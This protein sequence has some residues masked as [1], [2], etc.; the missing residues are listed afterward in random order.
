MK[1]SR[2]RAQVAPERLNYL[3]SGRPIR[4]GADPPEV[5]NGLPD[6]LESLF[7]RSAATHPHTGQLPHG[8]AQPGPPSRT[9]QQSGPPRI[10]AETPPSRATP[11]AASIRSSPDPPDWLEAPNV[12]VPP[13]PEPERTPA[14]HQ[15]PSAADQN[16][17]NSR[18][19][20][21]LAPGQPGVRALAAIGVL[22]A[23]IASAYLWTSRP[24]PEATP[25]HPA[26]PSLISAPPDSA[27]RQPQPTTTSATKVFVHV[28][29]K[30]RRPGV[31]SLTAGS[32]VTDAI[33]A[34]G[35]L[36]PGARTGPLNL[37]R[38]LVDG[39]QLR[40][41]IPGHPEPPA[42]PNPPS[43]PATATT[44]GAPTPLDLNTATEEQF[45]ALPGVG[46]VLARRIIDYRTRNGGFRTVEQ[47]QEVSGIG[48][49][50]YA[51]LKPLVRV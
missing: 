21:R 10:R 50:R 45:D 4:P 34:A 13:P 5:F 48:T 31:V 20:A 16:T 19:L 44:P 51:D 47:L 6:D 18:L 33:T 2:K 12:K 38:R 15:L 43:D 7:A 32:R 8:Q 29:G 23:L 24:K 35:G 40:I 3:V 17:A 14:S 28:A 37:A 9:S 39:E 25:P 1:N 42:P 46:P 11:P 30:V 49:R 22:A 41:D 36:R 27:L 26:A